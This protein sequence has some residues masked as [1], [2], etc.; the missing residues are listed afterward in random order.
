[1]Q[2]KDEPQ[3]IPKDHQNSHDHKFILEQI[4]HQM[5]ICS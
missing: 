3:N 1:M 4:T 5:R 2:E